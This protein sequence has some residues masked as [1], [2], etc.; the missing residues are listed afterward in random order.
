MFPYII[1]R[2]VFSVYMSHSKVS[3]TDLAT[4]NL[5]PISPLHKPHILGKGQAEGKKLQG[6]SNGSSVTYE[7]SSSLSH[8]D[9]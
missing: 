1:Q 7:M 4:K 3:S 2:T 8:P 9:K 5:S 6:R